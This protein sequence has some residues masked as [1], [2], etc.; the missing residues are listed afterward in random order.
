MYWSGSGFVLQQ[1]TNLSVPGGWVNAPSG[2]AN[3]ATNTIEAGSHFYRLKWP[4]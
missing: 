4:Q 2:T 1:N 3:P